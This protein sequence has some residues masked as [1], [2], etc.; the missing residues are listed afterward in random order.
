MAAARSL[1]RTK[2][3]YC[4]LYPTNAT[5]LISDSPMPL[6]T[7]ET[8]YPT[9]EKEE[10]ENPFSPASPAAAAAPRIEALI[11][12]WLYRV[13]TPPPLSLS[14]VR[15]RLRP[16][17]TEAVKPHWSVREEPPPKEPITL[18]LSSLFHSR[19]LERSTEEEE[20][21]KERALS[22]KGRE[23]RRKGDRPFVRPIDA[24]PKR[25]REKR[26]KGDWKKSPSPFK[27]KRKEGKRIL[28]KGGGALFCP[29]R[30][31]RWK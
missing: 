3:T 20:E 12:Y 5:P 2:A 6:H 1:A 21:G 28:A 11:G 7:K 23:K 15:Y 31:K 9:K 25:E 16:P 26:R 29:L 14:S 27:P 24:P 22:S 4:A 18:F 17:P 10:S 13:S 30:R 8:Q 19:S